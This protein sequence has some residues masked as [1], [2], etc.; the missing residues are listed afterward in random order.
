MRY[1]VLLKLETRACHSIFGSVNYTNKF[2]AVFPRFLFVAYASI[3]YWLVLFWQSSYFPKII[4]KI[5]VNITNYMLFDV[6]HRHSYIHCYVDWHESS[7]K[8]MIYI[9][10]L[11][12]VIYN[13]VD[14]YLLYAKKFHEQFIKRKTQNAMFPVLDWKKVAD[15]S[16]TKCAVFDPPLLKNFLRLCTG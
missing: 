8:D 4:V 10:I 13:P 14:G 5:I 12:F 15:C 9:I 16:A 7:S 6:V 2:S 1:V 3:S 11:K